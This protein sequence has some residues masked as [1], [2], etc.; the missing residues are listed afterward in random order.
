[1]FNVFPYENEKDSD[2]LYPR[3][4]HFPPKNDRVFRQK[5]MI[6]GEKAAKRLLKEL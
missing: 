3:P 5:E 6:N 1:M 2:D 4:S